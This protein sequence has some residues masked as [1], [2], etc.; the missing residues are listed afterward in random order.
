MH[1]F[2]DLLRRVIDRLLLID[3][4]LED[5]RVEEPELPPRPDPPDASWAFACG[6]IVTALSIIPIE[7]FLKRPHSE[8]MVS[9]VVALSAGAVGAGLTLYRRYVLGYGD[10]FHGTLGVV[11]RFA[12]GYLVAALVVFPVVF[13]DLSLGFDTA[14]LGLFLLVV[15]SAASMAIDAADKG[16][17]FWDQAIRIDLE[18]HLP[19]WLIDAITYEPALAARLVAW[20]QHEPPEEAPTGPLGRVWRSATVGLRSGVGWV[21]LIDV[22]EEE[23]EVPLEVDQTDDTREAAASLPRAG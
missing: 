18:S 2:V 19:D 10:Y 21:L 1:Q 17:E 8:G 9:F 23:C 4:D 13:S 5:A 22:E 6:A 12:A 20:V 16:D 15:G 14:F 11:I 7:A 3:D